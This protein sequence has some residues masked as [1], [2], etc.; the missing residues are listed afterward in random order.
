MQKRKSLSPKLREAVYLK[1][2][3]HCA[4][5]GKK[6]TAKEFQVDHLVPVQRERFGKYS[7]DQIE[8][9]ENYIPSC[10]VCNHYKRAHS[11]ETFRR[12]I[13]EIPKKLER[14]SYIY[15][16]GKKYNLIEEHPQKIAFYFEEIDEARKQLLEQNSNQK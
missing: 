14:D 15:R 2:D 12:Y 8:R 9:F 3:G 16:I 7:E 11:L 5:C 4:Y 10:R 13:E 6:L 1:Y